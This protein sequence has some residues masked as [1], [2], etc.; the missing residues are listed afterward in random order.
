MHNPGKAHWEAVKLILCYL[1]GSP[2][3]SLVFYQHRVDPGG[4]VGYVDAD[5]GGDF[6]RRR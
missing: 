5:Y 2:E 1:K 3:I 6:D 4:V